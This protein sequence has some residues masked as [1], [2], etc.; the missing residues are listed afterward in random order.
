[1]H[2]FQYKFSSMTG[3]TSVRLTC[4]R[5]CHLLWN[6]VGCLCAVLVSQQI[7]GAALHHWVTPAALDSH[8]VVC[9]LQTQTRE[10][11]W[12]LNFTQVYVNVYVFLGCG[13]SLW[14]WWTILW[15]INQTGD[16]QI[17]FFF[18]CSWVFCTK[19]SR[20]DIRANVGGVGAQGCCLSAHWS[21]S[22]LTHI[23]IVWF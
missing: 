13:P 10:I 12:G 15:L 7:R 11:S 23:Y 5:C 8:A 9:H 21:V 22:A 3:F 17:S 20:R 14:L 4:C 6:D 2:N 16:T 18:S 19:S 1:M